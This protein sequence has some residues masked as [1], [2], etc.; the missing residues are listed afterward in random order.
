MIYYIVAPAFKTRNRTFEADPAI[1]ALLHEMTKNPQTLKAWRSLVSDAFSD[2][3]FFNA[4]P[5]A[6]VDWRPLVQA[7]MQSDKE[8]FADLASKISTASSANIFTNRE[9]ESLSRALSLRRLT[10]VLLTGPKDRHLNQ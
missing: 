7:L 8:R 4:P 1:F 10:Y 3:R 9:L 5:S 2:N 6:N